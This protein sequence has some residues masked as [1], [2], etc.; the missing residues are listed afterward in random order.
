MVKR[1]LMPGLSVIIATHNRAA[2]V[3]RAVE[4]VRGAG[5]DLEIIVVDDASTDDTADVCAQLSGIRYLRLPSNRGLAEARNAGMLASSAEFVAFLDD[6]DQRLPGS[7]DLQL[8]MLMDA[9][10]A[11]FSYGRLLA[12]DPV[13]H[14]PTGV[15]VPE[16]AP[17]GDVFWELLE[18]NFISPITVVA[19]KQIVIGQGG[20]KSGLGGVEDWD[21]WLRLTER[22][23]VILAPEAVAIYRR[24]SLQSGQ[25]CSDSISIFRNMLH[26]QDMALHS[27]R[28]LA[29]PSWRRRQARTRLLRTLY[30]ALLYEA[31][32]ALAEGD[33]VMA[34]A[35]SR[36]A[37][38]LR[39][40]RGR[41]DLNLLKLCRAAGFA[42]SD[43]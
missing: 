26:V 8:Q 29:A 18:Q 39:P 15:I 5:S 40:L 7:L 22:W 19:R 6:D 33:D 37:L 41:V 20:F 25:M 21:L 32:S 30:N 1:I 27:Q 38:R 4:S 31:E 35:K 10:D 43:I 3:A 24:A 28:G 17:Q 11:A 34:R 13:H 14:L 23:P 9:E 16:I 12:S 2:L 42:V 36:E